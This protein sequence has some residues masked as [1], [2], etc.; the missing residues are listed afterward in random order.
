MNKCKHVQG[1]FLLMIPIL[2][3]VQACVESNDRLEMERPAVSYLKE[4]ISPCIPVDGSEQNPCPKGVPALVET[5]SVNATHPLWPHLDHQWTFTDM[6]LGFL[7]S[8]P[9][10]HHPIFA[11][12]IV[13]RGIAIKDTTRCGLYPIE[14]F[15]FQLDDSNSS[16]WPSG[17]HH[18]FC[19]VDI[20]VKEYI[21]GVGPSKL[22]VKLY[23]DAGY[24]ILNEEERKFYTEERLDEFYANV[25]SQFMLAYEGKEYILM[26]RPVATVS[27]EAWTISPFGLWFIQQGEDREIRAVSNAYENA[28][29]DEHR[30]LLNLPLDEMVRRIEEAHE[31]RNAR[32]GGRIGEDPALPMLVTDANY[33]QDYYLAAGAVYEGDNA[34]RLPP[35]APFPS[36]PSGWRIGS[37]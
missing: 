28:L 7:P 22:T 23:G 15:N 13:I 36:W 8:G 33:L 34:T 37:W 25:K 14:S 31:N 17:W 18:Y 2:L 9:G 30:S 29:T 1:M 3:L 10:G 6:F 5:P 4:T 12:H 16:G 35:P 20:A 21:T 24:L 11:P 19:F 27:L 26:L 32:T